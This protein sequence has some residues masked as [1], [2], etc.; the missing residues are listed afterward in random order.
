MKPAFLPGRKPLL[1]AAC[2]VVFAGCTPLSQQYPPGTDYATLVQA[3][4]E[5]TVTCPTADGGR[6]AVWS[7]Q[8]YEQSAV[9]TEQ[10]PDGTTSGL[11][12]I[13]TDRA[14][15]SMR[16]GAVSTCHVRSTSA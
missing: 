2:A 12:S 14:F 8:P 10:R 1:V 15:Y 7:R 5:P 9:A 13:L 6:R 3:L 4:G 16:D 11:E